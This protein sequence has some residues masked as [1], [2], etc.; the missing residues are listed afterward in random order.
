[1]FPFCK[2]GS[3]RFA[4]QPY[5]IVWHLLIIK[6][7]VLAS[8]SKTVFLCKPPLFSFAKAAAALWFQQL[9]CAAGSLTGGFFGAGALARLGSGGLGGRLH[10]GRCGN[11]AHGFD[12]L[13]GHKI[14]APGLVFAVHIV[15]DLCLR[16][17]FNAHILQVDHLFGQHW[18][19]PGVLAHWCTHVPLALPPSARSMAL[20]VKQF[21]MRHS[22]SPASTNFHCC[23]GWPS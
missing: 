17:V 1:M 6:K 16:A 19:L 11:L 8:K 15:P 18:L 4:A 2:S 7:T 21:T 14:D 10:R 22:F 13:G 23:Q 3:R 12:L 20:S 9:F 5:K